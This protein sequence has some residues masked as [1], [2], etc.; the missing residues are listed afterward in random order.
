MLS[1]RSSGAR[2]VLGCLIASVLAACSGGPERSKLNVVRDRA[3]SASKRTQAV[4]DIRAE[5]SAAARAGEGAITP[6]DVYKEIAWTVSEPPRLRAAVVDALLN[7]RDPAVVTEAKEMAKLLLPKEITREVVVAICRNAGTKGWTDFAPAIVR[8]YSRPLPGVAEEDRV[9][10]KA[11]T[12]LFPGQPVDDTVFSVFMTPPVVPPT[13]GIDWTMRY[14]A[15][16]WN[17]LARVDPDG[18][19]RGA[20]LDAA[21]PGA[22]SDSL[23]EA[24]RA[25][26]ADLRTVPISG[27]ELTWLASLRSPRRKENAAWWQAATAAVT[28][29]PAN[30]VLRMRHIEPI[31]W[32]AANRP[33]ALAMSRADLEQAVRARLKGREFHQRTVSEGT[34][35]DGPLKSELFDRRASELSWGDLLTLLIID[36]SIRQPHIVKAHFAQASS[37][38]ADKST[39]YGGL[40]AFTPVRSEPERAVVMLYMPRGAQRRGDTQFVASDDM[41]G[42]SDLALAH[43]HFHVQ[44]ERNGEY[45]GPSRADLEYASRFGR[46]CI[47][48][49]SIREGVMAVDY[50]QPGEVNIDLGG[51][52]AMP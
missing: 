20:M 30:E 31:R 1:A 5:Q 36:E 8:A 45:A 25:A 32:A 23:V 4:E 7:D 43:Y 51:L 29:A 42:A 15:D 18:K 44:T 24:L 40:L 10:R 27:E 39:E 46:A 33:D 38:R 19:L 37:D 47:V 22:G 52:A 13:E 12:D 41:I 16:A 21:R 17:V 48:L 9:E 26:K 50:Y 34:K 14:R 11:L 2:L 28:K 49:T 35:N 3:E 6:K